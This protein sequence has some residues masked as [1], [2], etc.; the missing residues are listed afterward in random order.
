MTLCSF[1]QVEKHHRSHIIN[2]LE[3]VSFFLEHQGHMK[4]TMKLGA[5]IDN[6]VNLIVSRLICILFAE[7]S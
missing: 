3:D 4:E 1:P 7:N 6:I 5:T 2:V